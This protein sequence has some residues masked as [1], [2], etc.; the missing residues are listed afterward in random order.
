MTRTSKIATLACA[1]GIAGCG[2]DRVAGNS[3]ETENT[4]NAR[5]M[6][7]DSI[8]PAWN[9]PAGGTVATLRFDRGNFD[10]AASTGDGHDLQFTRQDGKSLPFLVGVWDSIS[11]KGRVLVRMDDSLLLAGAR[12]RMR[13][14]VQQTT[15]SNPSAT[16]AGISESTRLLANSAL[17]DDFEDG[18][19]INSLPVAN[20]WYAS[21]YGPSSSVSGISIDSAG[22]GR[23]GQALHIT[24]TAPAATSTTQYVVVATYLGS[25]PD[26]LRSLDSLV[27]WARGSGTLYVAMEHLT[28]SAGPKAWMHFT[29]DSA[30]WTRKCVR[31]TDF[32]AADGV[33]NNYGWNFVRDSVTTLTFLVKGGS[34]LWLDDVRLHGVNRD[35]LK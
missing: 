22:L 11:G 15:L 17:V 28:N 10:F 9:H 24:Y 8:L 33:G 14:G 29:L 4:A 5:V 2:I 7:V 23:S 3:V 19:T 13:W 25:M 26:C 18:N 21:A 6:P 1:M 20:T 35:D 32:D 16:W 30:A 34:N 31:P 27:F 12:I